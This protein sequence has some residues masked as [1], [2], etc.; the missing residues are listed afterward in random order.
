MEIIFNL[1]VKTYLIFGKQFTVLKIVNRFPKLNSSS[2]HAR[3][4]S[5]YRNSGI[6][7]LRN[8]ANAGVR[9]HPVARILPVLEFGRHPAIVAWMPADQIPAMVRSLPDPAKLACRNPATATG[10]CRISTKF[11]KF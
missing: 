5:D 7:G 2:L 3:L 8:P 1:T 11:A 6:V 10:H 9:Q 4:I